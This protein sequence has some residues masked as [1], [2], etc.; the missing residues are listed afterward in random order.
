MFGKDVW[1]RCVLGALF[2]AKWLIKVCSRGTLVLL[3]RI[4]QFVKKLI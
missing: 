3:L 2:P 1:F 4:S